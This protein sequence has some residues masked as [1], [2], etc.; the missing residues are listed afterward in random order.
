M[1]VNLSL[2]DTHVT[3]IER[4]KDK[5]SI[6]SDEEIVSRYVTSA[7]R[8]EDLDA[9]FGIPREQ[10]GAGCFDA[11]PRFEINID[12]ADYESLGKMYEDYAFQPY[13]TKDEQISKTIRCVLNF[14]EEEP[15][16]ILI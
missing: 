6:A 12:D 14:V 13:V 3:I 4:L 11:E 5:H 7:L 1:K 8:H 9:I 15:D 16:S 10:C 2:K